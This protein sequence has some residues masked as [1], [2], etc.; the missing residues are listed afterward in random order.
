MLPFVFC[1]STIGAITKFIDLCLPLTDLFSLADFCLLTIYKLVFSVFLTKENNG[2]KAQL[3]SN[4]WFIFSGH[5][6]YRLCV[7]NTVVFRNRS[8]TTGPLLT[9]WNV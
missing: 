3:K 8:Y 5:S 7:R 6:K 9:N 2:G 1:S 4:A